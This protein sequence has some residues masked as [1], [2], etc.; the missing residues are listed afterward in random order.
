MPGIYYTNKPTTLKTSIMINKIRI[1]KDN[2]QAIYNHFDQ[3]VLGKVSLSTNEKANLFIQ[4]LINPSE[5]YLH[6]TRKNTVV[7]KAFGE[8]SIPTNQFTAFFQHFDG[9][10]KEKE[11]LTGLLDRLIEDA[12]RRK[13][14]EYFTPKAWVNE[15]NKMI[16]EAFGEDWKETHV[17]WDCACGSGNLTRD[18]NFKELYCSTLEQSD[19]DTAKQMKYNPEATW[20]QFDFLNDRADKLPAQL[21]QHINEGKEILFFINPPYGRANEGGKTSTVSKGS[22]DTVIASEMKGEK[23]GACSAQLYAQFL[24]RIWKLRNVKIAVF[25]PSLYKSGSSFKIFRKH[26]YDRFQYVD[27]MLF[28]ASH[29]SDTSNAWGIDFSIWEQGKETRDS[30][31]AS[32]KDTSLGGIVKIQNKEIYHLDHTVPASKWVREEVKGLKTFDAPQISS[33]LKVK[34]NG[35]GNIV[36]GSLG[37]M[38]TAS[39]NIYKNPTYVFILSGTASMGHGVSVTSNNIY[40]IHTLFA[41]RKTVDPTWINDKDEYMAPDEHHPEWQQFVNDS[42]VYSLFNNSSHQSSLRQ[43]DYKE[44]KWDIKNEF[45]WLS[46]ESMKAAADKYHFDE[47]YQDARTASD[48]FVYQKLQGLELSDDA[49]EILDMA[50]VMVFQAM[51]YR[52]MMHEAHPEYH[53]N[54]WDAGYAQ[55]KLV[56]KECMPEEFK[57]FRA[58]Y[59]AFEDRLVPLVYDLGFLRKDPEPE[60][61]P[62]IIS[63]SHYSL[64]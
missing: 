41:A 62:Q 31:S 57:L 61:E 7:T 56:W 54:A 5:N 8:L 58:K 26:F 23:W 55:L 4:I 32:V 2:I 34:Q 16:S 15:A 20:F 38:V 18:F 37:Y 40:K 27:G 43:V 33:A 59:K 12:T 49:R 47:M 46:A 42:L 60:P 36:P 29:F 51:P 13:K 11:E 30:L 35:C 17:V 64:L 24:Y 21:Q 53:L 6:P 9:D 50:S 48:R 44:K 22:T 25:S 19:I 39:N 3:H 63:S 14:G 52:S 28:N 10:D 45:F 1:T